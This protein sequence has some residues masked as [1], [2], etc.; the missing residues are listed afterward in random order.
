MPYSLWSMPLIPPFPSLAQ[1]TIGQPMITSQSSMSSV[2][3]G[4][5]PNRM[6][7]LGSGF[8]PSS[9]TLVGSIVMSSTSYPFGW[10]WNSGVSSQTINFI[11][12]V[13]PSSVLPYPGGSNVFG[14]L[15]FVG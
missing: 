13:P 2:Q 1:Y 5:G 9:G 12:S 10:N 11:L 8:P 7:N 6:T 3:F 4:I 15:S 14:S